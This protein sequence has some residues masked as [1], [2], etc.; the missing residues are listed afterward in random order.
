MYGFGA[1]PFCAVIIAGFS[2]SVWICAFFVFSCALFAKLHV[3]AVFLHFF[4]ANRRQKAYFRAIFSPAI[5]GEDPAGSICRQNSAPFFVFFSDL[6][7]LCNACIG[8][9]YL[10]DNVICSLGD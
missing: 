5:Y 1:S 9:M 7:H 4:E 2:R 3:F 10:Y 6:S 8:I